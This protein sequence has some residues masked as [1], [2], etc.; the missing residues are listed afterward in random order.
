MKKLVIM[1]MCLA[2]GALF[3]QTPQANCDDCSFSQI[4]SGPRGAVDNTSDITQKGIL[5]TANAYQ[6]GNGNYSIIDQDGKNMGVGNGGDSNNSRVYQEGVRNHSDVKQDG[7]R[8]IGVVEQ[9]GYENFAKQDVGVGYSE[10][11]VTSA[12]QTGTLNTSFQ[13]QRYDNNTATVTQVGTGLLGLGANYAEQDQSS[14]ANGVAGSVAEIDQTG[15]FNEAKQ[16]QRGSN[17]DAYSLQNGIGN[18][19]AEDQTSVAG[20]TYSNTSTVDQTFV[21]TPWLGSNLACV[22]QASVAGS[23]TSAITQTNVAGINAWTPGNSA[24]V[25]QTANLSSNMSTIM[26]S[27]GANQACVEQIGN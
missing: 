7:D 8:N 3:A 22:T 9:R 20:S 18:T 6:I 13:K 24:I 10:D 14:M 11:N 17:N 25:N 4:N 27:G 19:S 1:A 15:T 16:V 5:N 21:G 23:N 2:T 26:Q 12:F